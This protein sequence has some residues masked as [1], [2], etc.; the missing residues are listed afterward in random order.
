MIL[1]RKKRYDKIEAT[2]KRMKATLEQDGDIY[3]RS[4]DFCSSG[5]FLSQDEAK[6]TVELL[7]A[8]LSEMKDQSKK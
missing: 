5:L 3:V 6:E 4:T 7:K 2:G 1:N 8:I